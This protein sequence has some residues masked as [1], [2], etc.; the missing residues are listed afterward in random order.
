MSANGPTT[1]D[2]GGQF[3]RRLAIVT[4]SVLL[5]VLV[6]HL[7]RELRVLLQPLCIA[8]LIAYAIL[9]PHRWLVRRRIRPSLAYVLLVV[10][11]V[12]A[13]AVTG[14][15]AYHNISELTAD[16]SRLDRYRDR[17]TRLESSAAR[18][19]E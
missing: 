10:L 12:G 16:Q 6:I 13:V 19:M 8:L 7:L 5:V 2:A 11:L 18:L 4:L 15:A 3:L 14:Q 17:I 1:P 9:P